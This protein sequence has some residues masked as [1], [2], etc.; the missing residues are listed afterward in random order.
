VHPPQPP[1]GDDLLRLAPLTAP[2]VQEIDL[3]G[4]VEGFRELAWGAPISAEQIH[5]ELMRGVHG[6]S[7]VAEVEVLRLNFLRWNFAVRLNDA[8]LVGEI[9]FEWFTVPGRGNDAVAVSYWTA[10]DHRRRGYATRFLR[11]ATPWA[12]TAFGVREI[13]LHP[14]KDVSAAVARK[15]GY[16]KTRR[17]MRG[18]PLYRRPA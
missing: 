16:T 11:L 3:I 15:A 9:G 18:G 2:D 6:W 5:H 1:L 8:R 4:D 17:R 7:P 12:M 10:P 13:W 14:N